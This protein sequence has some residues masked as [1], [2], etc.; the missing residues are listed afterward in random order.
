MTLT[1]E[2]VPAASG[3]TPAR[4]SLGFREIGVILGGSNL[5]SM[6]LFGTWVVWLADTGERADSPNVES[7]VLGASAILW[8]VLCCC[9]ALAGNCLIG[10]WRGEQ[11]ASTAVTV[12]FGFFAAATVGVLLAAEARLTGFVATAL[13][14]LPDFVPL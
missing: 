13:P 2:P 4:S 3:S 6:V 11:W 9:A 1:A 10:M 7:F 5:V 12:I 14:H 8:A